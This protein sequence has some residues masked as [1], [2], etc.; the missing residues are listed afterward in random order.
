MLI[1]VYQALSEAIIEWLWNKSPLPHLPFVSAKALPSMAMRALS[2]LARR[3]DINREA[4]IIIVISGSD[5]TN[6]L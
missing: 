2:C 5:P 1:K 3:L 4:E 6:S